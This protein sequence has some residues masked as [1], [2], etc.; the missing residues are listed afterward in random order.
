MRPLFALKAACLALLLIAL[1]QRRP[2]PLP[3]S[4][5]RAPAAPQALHLLAAMW[6]GGPTLAPDTVSY[7][8]ALKACANAFQ[9]GRALEVYREM[10]GR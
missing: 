9:L 10:V 5:R 6:E 4:C 3:P 1:K 8:T 2:G 7:N